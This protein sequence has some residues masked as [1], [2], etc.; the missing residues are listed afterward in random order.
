MPPPVHEP[1]VST[2][3]PEYQPAKEAP[4]HSKL[5]KSA[6]QRAAELLS[7][8]TN[9][10][11]ELG[12]RAGSD[13]ADALKLLDAISENTSQLLDVNQRLV[14]L[15]T[16]FQ[17]QASKHKLWRWFTGEQ[18]EHEVFLHDVSKQI[19]NLVETGQQGHAGMG[20]QVQ[21]LT[22]QYKLMGTEIELL[23]SDIEAGRLLASPG[24][25]A[26]RLAAG[27]SEEDMARLARRTAN[28]ETMA[29]ATQ[30]TRAQYQVAIQHAKSVSDRYREIRTLL[31]PIWKQAVG[32]DLF[33]RRVSTHID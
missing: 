16:S 17:R 20:K 24:Y 6:S 11:D 30:L 9:A 7:Y 15:M 8:G 21:L 29:I 3:I 26:Q 14:P 5:R 22:T 2:V 18:L 4:L 19:E 25:A 1:A 33:S 10:V 13:A 12:R 23:E 27:L 32:F 28:L 31:L